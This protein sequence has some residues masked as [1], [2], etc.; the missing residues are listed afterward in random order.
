MSIVKKRAYIATLLLG[1]L[2]LGT[3]I[4]YG[5]DLQVDEKLPTGFDDVTYLPIAKGSV[6]LLAPDCTFLEEDGVV[7]MEVES[8]RFDD[9][10]W[11]L[12]N[13]VPTAYVSD[14]YM[15]WRGPEYLGVPGIGVASYPI[16]ITNPGDYRL[17]I[18]NWHQAPQPDQQN[19]IWV[20][21][22]GGPW[23]KLFSAFEGIWNWHALLDYGNHNFADPIFSL[24]PGDHLLE[25]AA[26]SAG[27]RMDRFDLYLP[28]AD[29][30]NLSRPQSICAAPINP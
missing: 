12:E 15:V 22:D 20:R 18:L 6:Q 13:D 28:G 2:L 23:V 25:I 27:F 24:G 11:R 7:V 16:R 14:G 10:N 4:L 29:G 30:Q 8:A 17:Y 3:G 1:V 9:P 5:S 26:R 19:D 21:M